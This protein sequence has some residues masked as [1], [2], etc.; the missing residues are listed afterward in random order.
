MS[1]KI[2][3]FLGAPIEV[4]SERR[5][6]RTLIEDLKERGDDAL[7]LANFLLPPQNPLHQIDYLIVLRRLVCHVELKNLTAPVIGKVNGPW[8]LLLPDGTK[9]PLHQNP[10]RQALDCKC[11]AQGS[12]ESRSERLL[13]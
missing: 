4:E 10:Y 2:E 13:W 1:A 12:W 11:I 6:L 3:V 5:C 8:D 9:K 7:I